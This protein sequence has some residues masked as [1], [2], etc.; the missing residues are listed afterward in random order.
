MATNNKEDKRNFPKVLLATPTAEVKD[1][2]MLDWI[3]HIK[4]LTYPNLDI[5]IVDNSDNPEYYKKIKKALGDRGKVIHVKRKENQRIHELMCDCNNKIRA[6]VINKKNDYKF[7]FSLE[8][9]L[10]PPLNIIE[11]LL[12]QRKPFIGVPYFTGQHYASAIIDY[13]EERF[14]Y[15]R[16]LDVS[17]MK[18]FIKYDGKL[19]L[20]NNTGIG[21]TMIHRDILKKVKFRTELEYN[22]WADSY[23]HSDIY[24]KFNIQPYLTSD[25]IVEH[26]NSDWRKVYKKENI[27]ND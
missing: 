4:K 17:L 1:Y 3:S 23:F 13:H 27:K 2:C 25:I 20:G 15:P 5:L 10:F 11:Y 19:V 12:L 16:G 24:D 6:S 9:D 8:S 21:C 18:S 14:G 22:I 26:R 7:L